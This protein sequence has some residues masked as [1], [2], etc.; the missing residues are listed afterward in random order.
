[1]ENLAN[2][3]CSSKDEKKNPTDKI[4]GNLLVYSFLK[5]S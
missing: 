3:P 1:M 2:P 5:R 4:G